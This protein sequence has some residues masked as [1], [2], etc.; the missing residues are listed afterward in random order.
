MEIARIVL[1][2][3][4][5]ISCKKEHTN[6]AH[7]PGGIFEIGEKDNSINPLQQVSLNPFTIGRYEVTNQEF[8]YFVEATNYVTDAEKYKDALVYDKS[9]PEFEWK[10]DST[11]NWRFPQGISKGGIE[12]KMNHPVTSISFNDAMFYCEWANVRLPLLAEWEVASRGIQN[13][14]YF[15]NEEKAT[16]IHNYGNIWKGENHQSISLNESHVFTAPVGSYLPNSFGLYDVYGNVFEFCLDKPESFL[17]NK[18]LAA[19]RGG[20][21]WCSNNS[22]NFFNSHDIGRIIKQASF[23]NVGFRVVKNE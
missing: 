8:K 19:A 9:L 6:F 16:D 18:Q 21:W 7:I 1:L 23:S 17:N 11:A 20:S 10:T 2:C 13:Q 5:F 3:F 22:C 14:K 15:F 12:K 4:I